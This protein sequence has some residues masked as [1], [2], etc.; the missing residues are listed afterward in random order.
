MDDDKSQA[1]PYFG[2]AWNPNI[3][4]HHP[5]VP[6][7]VGSACSYCEEEVVEGDQGF[8]IPHGQAITQNEEGVFDQMVAVFRPVHLD[9]FLRQIYGSVG[10]QKKTCSCFGGK[11]ED[12]EGMTKREAA[13]AAVRMYESHMRGS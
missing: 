3:D 11:E 1:N 2:K 13:T 12:P 8:I 10:H 7:P 6:T 5:Q 4:K 9:C